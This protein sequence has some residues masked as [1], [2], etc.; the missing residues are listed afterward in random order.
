MCRGGSSPAFLPKSSAGENQ[1]STQCEI[2]RRE[3][4]D[5]I[6]TGTARL[7]DDADST[8]ERPPSAE[9]P[10]RIV[11]ATDGTPE[12]H[13]IHRIPESRWNLGVLKRDERTVL[14]ARR[15]V[16]ACKRGRARVRGHNQ[17]RP[18]KCC[19]PDDRVGGHRVDRVC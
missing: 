4:R 3:V 12:Q 2:A 7:G 18:G 10:P 17:D 14:P 15:G 11:R 16:A 9:P 6:D 19:T 13:R 8:G 5:A 1:L